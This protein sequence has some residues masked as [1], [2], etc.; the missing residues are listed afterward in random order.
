MRYLKKIKISVGLPNLL[1]FIL[2]SRAIIK[3]KLLFLLSVPHIGIHSPL[4]NCEQSGPPTETPLKFLCLQ[5]L[6][7][8][9][10]LFSLL[11]A[12]NEQT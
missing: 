4:S 7:K 6:C 5:S 3:K 9:A 2:D 10:K 8:Y 12:T 1:C 11:P